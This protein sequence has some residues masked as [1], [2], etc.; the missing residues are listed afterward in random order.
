MYLTHA[1]TSNGRKIARIARIFT[2]LRPKKSQR[3]DLFLQK[4]L[5]EW[6]NE[7]TEK[8]FETFTKIL[9]NVKIAT[10]I[11]KIYK[12]I[13]FEGAGNKRTSPSNSTRKTTHI[14]LFSSLYD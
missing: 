5:N 6:R 10:K 3:R 2:I 14:D 13:D 7:E 12:N 9:E 1:K 4:K 8:D 11:E